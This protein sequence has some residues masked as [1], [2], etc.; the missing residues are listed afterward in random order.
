MGRAHPNH[1]AFRVFFSCPLGHASVR[2]PQE[3]RR[4]NLSCPAMLSL[5]RT[6]QI[7][8]ASSL[9]CTVLSAPNIPPSSRISTLIKLSA[10]WLPLTRFPHTAE[11]PSRTRAMTRLVQAPQLHPLEVRL[12]HGLISTTTNGS[13][14][15]L[16]TTTLFRFV[17]FPLPYPECDSRARAFPTHT[18]GH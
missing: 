11:L 7:P 2:P 9:L 13:R 6:H 12:R 10:P 14:L 8:A 15:Y 1:A 3:I 16:I 4:A 5:A 18:P 17:I